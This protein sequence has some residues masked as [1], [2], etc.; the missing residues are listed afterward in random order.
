MEL[1]KVIN[2]LIS[3]AEKLKK[4]TQFEMDKVEPYIYEDEQAYVN[5]VQAEN[6]QRE[7]LE[8]IKRAELFMTQLK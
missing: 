6:I 2:D 4:Y 8:A 7:T 5:Y 1:I 3:C